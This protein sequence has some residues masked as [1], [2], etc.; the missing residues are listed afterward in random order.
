M[1][2]GYS[3]FTPGS[4]VP[5]DLFVG[6]SQQIEEVMRYVRQAVSGRQENVFLTGDRGI[7]KSSFASFLRRVVATQNNVLGI[8]VFLG[9]VSTLEE[10]VRH[11]L[12]QLLRETREQGSFERIVEYFGDHVRQVG[13]FGVSVTFAPPERDLA[14]LVRSFPDALGNLVARIAD[15]KAGLLIILDDINGLAEKAEFANWYK[16]LADEIATRHGRFPV[17]IMPTGLPEK[18]DALA[19]LQPSLRRVFRVVE[20]ERLSDEEVR[21]FFARAFEEVGRQVEPEALSLLVQYSSGLPI[22]MQEIGDATY[23]VDE[24]Q[25]VDR[26]DASL[27]LIKAAGNVGNK[28]LDPKVYRAVRSQRYRSIIRKIARDPTSPGFTRNEVMSR[29][30][31][32]ETKVFDN[33]LRRLRELGVVEA[34]VEGGRGA[35][36]YANQMYPVYMWLESEQASQQ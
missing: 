24:D 36:R 31:K 25:V 14:D 4:P 3:P 1:D 8:H 35:Y 17:L 9:G 27:G 21:D 30:D 11:I 10:M 23:W 16:S 28:Y 13:L 5:I 7:G 22:I 19:A 20:I 32:K 34:D 15:D 29:L 12:E 18:R 2:K 33:L 26:T 6:R